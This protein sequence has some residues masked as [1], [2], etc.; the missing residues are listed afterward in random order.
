MCFTCSPSPNHHFK[1]V[2]AWV[3]LQVFLPNMKMKESSMSR[4]PEWDDYCARTGFLLPP[5]IALVRCISSAR[6]K[7]E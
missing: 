1:A 2:L 3:W 5:P 7:G 4:Y 6:T